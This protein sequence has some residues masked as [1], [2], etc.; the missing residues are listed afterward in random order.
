MWDWIGK[1]N[2]LNRTGSQFALVTV[3]DTKGSSPRD[4]GAKMIVLADGKFHGTIGGGQLEHLAIEDAVQALSESASG[5]KKYPLCFRAGQCCGGGVEVYIELV[6]ISP[7]LYIF[8]AGHVGQALARTMQGTPF[9]VHLVDER[10]E[11]IDLRGTDA[12]A[13]MIDRHLECPKKYLKQLQT[14][15]HRTYIVVMTHDHFL[16]L[17]LISKIAELPAKFIG[18]IGS[19]NKWQKFTQR[20]VHLGLNPDAISRVECPVG[21]HLGGKTP[22][23]ISISIGARLLQVFHETKQ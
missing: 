6:G 14:D 20:L 22:A 23:E 10:K 17:D 18:L 16:D 19:Q 12:S 9:R 7:Q 11:W 5:T 21:L 13:E 3:V 15:R 4:A 8:G 2:E 1:A